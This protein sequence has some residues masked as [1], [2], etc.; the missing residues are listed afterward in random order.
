MT[1]RASGP[2]SRPRS[3]HPLAGLLLP[4][5]P[6]AGRIPGEAPVNQRAVCAAEALAAVLSHSSLPSK[7]GGWGSVQTSEIL[8]KKQKQ[9]TRPPDCCRDGPAGTL[10]SSPS[11]LNPLGGSSRL[12]PPAACVRPTPKKCSQAFQKQSLQGKNSEQTQE[13][14]FSGPPW[15][16]LGSRRAAPRFRPGG[17]HPPAAPLHPVVPDEGDPSVQVGCP[18]S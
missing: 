17:A 3:R 1:P 2:R 4:R 11:G 18:L 7:S 5:R 12:M 9:N 14:D 10:R 16:L 6:P 13:M 8:E 15:S